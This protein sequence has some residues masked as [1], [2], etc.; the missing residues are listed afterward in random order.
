MKATLVSLVVVILLAGCHAPTTRVDSRG[1]P[2]LR[3]ISISCFSGHFK[4]S[5]YGVDDQAIQ[6][7]PGGQYTSIDL[8]RGRST[9][10]LFRNLSTKLLDI[11][12]EMPRK[13]DAP[14][15]HPGDRVASYTI[16]LVWEDDTETSHKI[17]HEQTVRRDGWVGEELDFGEFIRDFETLAIYLWEPGMELP[18]QSLQRTRNARR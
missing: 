4:G 10:A 8:Y 15:T 16:T 3:E 1:R 9:P 13:Y 7:A 5:L 11:L 14:N 2:E 12:P 6:Y 17:P 18:N